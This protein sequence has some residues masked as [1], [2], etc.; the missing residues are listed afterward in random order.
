MASTGDDSTGDPGANQSSTDRNPAPV[1]QPADISASKGS[2]HLDHGC[3]ALL[4]I[5]HPLTSS[6]FVFIEPC[7]VT[8]LVIIQ[9]SVC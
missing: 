6:L 8:L 4:R 3:L 7:F 2:R 9:K 5:Q 1:P